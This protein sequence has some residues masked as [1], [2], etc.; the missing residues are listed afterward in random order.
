MRESFLYPD[1]KFLCGYL[2]IIR[3]GEAEDRSNLRHSGCALSDR[4]APHI[5]DIARNVISSF[6]SFVEFFIGSEK[7]LFTG[8]PL[9]CTNQLRGF[10]FNFP[11]YPVDH[12]KDDIKDRRVYQDVRDEM[13]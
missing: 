6:V 7:N 2:H 9:G 4:E 11:A 1:N 12:D 3:K 10:L 5:G 8:R 13:K